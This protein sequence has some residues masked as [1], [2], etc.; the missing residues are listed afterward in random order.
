MHHLSGV[1]EENMTPVC[2]INKENIYKR[3][4]C[5]VIKLTSY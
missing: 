5:F 4:N 1:P 2:H 3:I